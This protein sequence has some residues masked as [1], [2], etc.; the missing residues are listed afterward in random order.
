LTHADA[1]LDELSMSAFVN[2]DDIARGLAGQAAQQSTYP[3]EVLN[4]ESSGHFF[5]QLTE[6]RTALVRTAQG[7]G[8]LSVRVLARLVD[9][10]VKRVHEDVVVLA[11]LGLLER[12]ESGGMV[13]P[14][15]S[16]H[17]DMVLKAA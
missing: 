5:G 4:F 7:K 16:M 14:Y 12:T 9:R 11:D 17:I 8:A 1:I 10:D 13:C 3:G 15:S 2:A 6:K